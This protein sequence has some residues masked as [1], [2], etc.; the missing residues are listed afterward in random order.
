MVLMM[1]GGMSEEGSQVRRSFA[2]MRDEVKID[3]HL[4]LIPL[5]PLIVYK[6]IYN[7]TLFRSGV[8]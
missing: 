8:G 3:T 7:V 4:S 5:I 2:E 6:S 1:F